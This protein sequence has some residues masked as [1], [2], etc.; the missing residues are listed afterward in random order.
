MNTIATDE[1][2]KAGCHGIVLGCILPVLTF[3][4]VRKNILNSILYTGWGIWELWHISGHL[5]KAQEDTCA[6]AHSPQR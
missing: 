6:T 2:F 4:V 3:N 1:V 5:L